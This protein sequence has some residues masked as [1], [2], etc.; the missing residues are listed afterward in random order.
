MRDRFGPEGAEQFDPFRVGIVN[1]MPSVGGGDQIRALAH[2]YPIS[3]PWG[4]RELRRLGGW[5][6]ALGQSVS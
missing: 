2:G 5:M 6:A 3:T 4:L 1:G